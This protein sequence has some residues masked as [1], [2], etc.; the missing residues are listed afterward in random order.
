MPLLL[1]LGLT[2]HISWFQIHRYRCHG[3]CN[4]HSV[5]AVAVVIV[6]LA[7]VRD[8]QERGRA[9]TG[10]A[11]SG[12]R[13]AKPRSPPGALAAGT[14][15]AQKEPRGRRHGPGL[16][17]V[18]R[19]RRGHRQL[20]RAGAHR[21]TRA[22]MLEGRA[23]AGLPLTPRPGPTHPTRSRVLQTWRN[24]MAVSLKLLQDS[25]ALVSQA[26]VKVSYC[27]AWARLGNS[28]SGFV[29][30][31]WPWMSGSDSKWSGAALR[32]AKHP[33]ASGRERG[34]AHLKGAAQEGTL[35]K[36][37]RRTTADQKHK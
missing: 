20:R 35:S 26:A 12:C 36:Q 24:A 5:L 37:A 33:G 4:K 23:S 14:A 31:A 21:M 19:A 34:H 27:L 8:P 16:Q 6:P 30:W 10:C 25:D 9:A 17:P 13:S 22:P 29:S 2:R 11:R 1:P 32:L 15:P 18:G 28:V 7:S 3:F